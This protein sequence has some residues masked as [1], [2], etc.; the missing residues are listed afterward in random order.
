MLKYFKNNNEL[1][2]IDLNTLKIKDKRKQ[3][4]YFK[5][6]FETK[7]LIGKCFRIILKKKKAIGIFK[8]EF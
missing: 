4:R 1:K 8:K 5:K 2:Q 3:L 7:Y 6:M